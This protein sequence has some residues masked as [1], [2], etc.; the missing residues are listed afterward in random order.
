MKLYRIWHEIKRFL[1]ENDPDDENFVFNEE[2]YV[3]I[4]D[5]FFEYTRAKVTYAIDLLIKEY[6]EYDLTV[7]RLK[8]LR[9]SYWMLRKPQAIYSPIFDQRILT[10]KLLGRP[11]PGLPPPS[12]FYI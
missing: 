7:V 12:E 8:G 10:E 6:T 9:Q 4:E 3:F 5:E 2:L 1:L 11:T